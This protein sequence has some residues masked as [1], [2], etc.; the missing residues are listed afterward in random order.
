M[1]RFIS[2]IFETI[3]SDKKL[4]LDLTERILFFLETN[5]W[6]P[7]VSLEKAAEYADRNANYISS[8]LAKKCGKSFRELLNE[9]RIR[10]SAKLLLESDMSIKEIAS[11]CG[12]SNQQYFNKVFSKLKGMPPNQFRKRMQKASV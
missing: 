11:V 6:D 2:F 5:Y 7:A 3:R 12:F 4:K 1:I 9:T 8:I 10:Q